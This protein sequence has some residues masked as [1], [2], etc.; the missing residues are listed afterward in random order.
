MH[1]LTCAVLML[2]MAASPAAAQTGQAML[3]PTTDDSPVSGQATFTET[4][5]GLEIVV[6]VGGV[7]SGAHGVHIHQFGRCEDGGKAAGGHYN[8]DHV[9]HGFAPKDGFEHAH[10]GDLGN[11]EVG[12]EGT[13]TLE[14]TVPGVRLTG[15]EPNILGRAVVLHEKPDDFSQPS[16]NAGGRIACGAIVFTA[17]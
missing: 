2:L 12:P 8:P 13:G 14:L 1:T 4:P 11:I 15:E 7:S 6:D 3:Q 10:P 16:G 5:E 9:P 17:E